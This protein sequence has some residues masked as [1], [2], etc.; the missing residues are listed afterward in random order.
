MNHYIMLITIFY[1]GL[2]GGLLQLLMRQ[3]N[4]YIGSGSSSMHKD[5]DQR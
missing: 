1:K 4:G 3:S 2:H 5:D